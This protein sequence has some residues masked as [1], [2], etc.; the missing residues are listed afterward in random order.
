MV[1]KICQHIFLLRDLTGRPV[2]TMFDFQSFIY[3]SMLLKTQ[4]KLQGTSGL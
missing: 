1:K 3:I 4:V 2:N